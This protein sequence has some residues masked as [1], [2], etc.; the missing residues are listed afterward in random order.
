MACVILVCESNTSVNFLFVNVLVW[1][2]L[3]RM[4]KCQSVLM[5]EWLASAQ[6]WQQA[7]PMPSA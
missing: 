1:N 7:D 4:L 6:E 3:Y 2:V 5:N